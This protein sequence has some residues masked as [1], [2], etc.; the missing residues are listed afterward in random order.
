MTRRY[1]FPEGHWDWP[2]KLTHHH[3]VR[4]GEMIFT[5]GQ[6]DLDAHGN[7]RNIGDLEA[8]CKNSMAYMADLFADLDV[9]F[10]DLVRLVV[11]YVG[12]A[13]D[14]AHLMELLSQIIGD[15]ARPVIS[16][17]NMPELCYPDMLTEIEGVAMRRPDGTRV[18][19]QCHRLDDM[20][21]LPDGFS[22][23]LRSGDMVFTS[24]MSALTSHGTVE[25]PGD[26]PTQTAKT[27]ERLTRALSAVGAELQDI[28]KLSTFYEDDLHGS[29][30][31][32][33]AGLRSA[34]FSDPGP[35]ATG[36]PVPGFAQEGLTTKI[37]ATAICA[38]E[39]D[40]KRRFSWPDGHWNWTAPLPYKHGN[41]CGNIIHIGGQVALDH[42]AN[43]L[44]SG[45]MVA[46]TRIAMDNL[47]KVLAEFDATLDHVV[48]VTTFYQGSASADALH[49]NLLIRSNSYTAP[50]PATTGIPVPALIYEGMVIEI[51]AIAILD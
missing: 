29:A 6:V 48:K 37:A 23:V 31:R 8:Q 42:Q 41:M 3:A 44:Q 25:A 9:E 1:S 14:E 21:Y 40:R 24:E 28:V 4:A 17:I 5:G 11:Y 35:A 13:A 49:E 27:M 2:V 45:D 33:A 47:S 20:P 12:D 15:T 19:K 30:W 32:K 10:D 18:P 51:E 46:Q 7:V 39:N 50:G 34:Y 38:P 43:V 22:H 26:I 16:M 36:I